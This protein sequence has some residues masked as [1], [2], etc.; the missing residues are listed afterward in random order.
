MPPPAA[1]QI[2]TFRGFLGGCYFPLI[3]DANQRG[4]AGPPRLGRKAVPQAPTRP[5]L[6]CSRRQEPGKDLRYRVIR[7]LYWAHFS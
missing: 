6:A 4:I 7:M 1:E 3:R 5:R 2:G